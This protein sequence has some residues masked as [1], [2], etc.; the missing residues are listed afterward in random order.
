MIASCV[1]LKTKWVA[2]SFLCLSTLV[3]SVYDSALHA[4]GLQHREIDQES[5]SRS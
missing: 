4:L 1:K 5:E 3:M 2:L